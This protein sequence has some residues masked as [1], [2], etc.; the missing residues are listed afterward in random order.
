MLVGRPTYI[1]AFNHGSES[2][3]ISRL[4]AWSME[5]AKINWNTYM[6]RRN[7]LDLGMFKFYFNQTILLLVGRPTYIYAF[8]HGSESVKI[9][10]L[11][12]WSME[13]A[14]INWNTYMERRNGLD[15]GM[16]RNDVL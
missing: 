5:K 7:G 15:L 3:K 14:K 8:N 4:S 10:R 12:A 13:K 9:S 16:V 1:Y 2:V 11:S 6:E